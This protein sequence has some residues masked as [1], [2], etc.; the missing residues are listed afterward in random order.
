M[1]LADFLSAMRVLILDGPV[2]PIEPNK[3]RAGLSER[4]PRLDPREID[5]LAALPPERLAV[6]SDLVYAGERG[7]LR[8]AFPMTFAAIDRI[9][10]SS[11]HLQIVRDLHRYRPWR[12]AST[13]ELAGIFH[14]YLL[15]CRRGWMENW[16]GLAALM[17]YER[18]DLEIFYAL[19]VPSAPWNGEEELRLRSRSVED[20]MMQRVYRPPHAVVKRFDCDIL[21]LADYWRAHLALPSS[22][23][24]IQTCHA[25]S[26][27]SPENFMPAWVRLSNA[28]HRALT[29]AAL[30]QPT[31]I[32]AIATAYLEAIA[33]SS[34]VDEE[35]LFGDFYHELVCWLSA[36]I[37][38]RAPPE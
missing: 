5:D 29:H 33:S 9:D 25:A 27:R 31:P 10:P 30:D 1:A 32:N 11:D 23:P 18:S 34:N 14:S 16:P 22:L 19:D 24:P 13:R 3:R 21:A 6:Y 28:G 20:L 4:F 37:L 7:A 12:S 15:E 38:L 26:G 36:G 2:L 35:R 8:W 17:D